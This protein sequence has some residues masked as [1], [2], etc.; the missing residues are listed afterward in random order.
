MAAILTGSARARAHGNDGKRTRLVALTIGVAMFAGLFAMPVGPARF[1]V[2]VTSGVLI[3]Q[4]LGCGVR[5]RPHT[6][7]AECDMTC[8]DAHVALELEML[9]LRD[10]G[11]A[12]S[13]HTAQRLDVITD[14]V[15]EIAD[16]VGR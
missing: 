14:M 7:P 13:H 12:R 5:R 1:V 9:T 6:G 2:A 15:A 3:V 11:E 10:W 4:A 16:Q 8:T